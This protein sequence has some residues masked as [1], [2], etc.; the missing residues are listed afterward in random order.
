MNDNQATPTQAS[1]FEGHTPGE[2]FHYDFDSPSPHGR[3]YVVAMTTNDTSIVRGYTVTCGQH[4]PKA[5]TYW[6]ASGV[7]GRSDD[8]ARA[9]A[10]LIAAAP[11]LL[12]ERD[13]LAKALEESR[14]QMLAAY[15]TLASWQ[16]MHGD[17]PHNSHNHEAV[18]AE[19]V[20]QIEAVRTLLSR[21]NTQGGAQ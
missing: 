15:G 1:E 7:G 8:E 2:W 17:K 16:A 12:R 20:Q 14:N 19:L 13:E 3:P 5:G 18:V 10:R 6:P 4:N 21:F 11:R 9:N